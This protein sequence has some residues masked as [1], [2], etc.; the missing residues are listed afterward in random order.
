MCDP[1]PPVAQ[2]LPIY[3]K[4]SLT[5]DIGGG[6]TEIVLGLDGQVHSKIQQGLHPQSHTMS[7]SA[8]KSF[9]C[10]QRS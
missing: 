6:S 8:V 3:D 4:L 2:A 5:V 10:R 7:V 1:A 9:I